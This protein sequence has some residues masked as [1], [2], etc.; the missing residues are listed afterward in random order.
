[1]TQAKTREQVV[2]AIYDA[3]L[4]PGSYDTFMDH[5]AETL[6]ESLDSLE[7]LKN[8][9]KDAGHLKDDPELEAHFERAFEILERFGRK[10]DATKPAEPITDNAVFAL[11]VNAQ[12]KIV[13]SSDKARKTLGPTPELPVLLK[14]L[15]S[16]SVTQLKNMLAG[17]GQRPANDAGVILTSDLD[18]GYLLARADVFDPA[19]DANGAT[20]TIEALEIPWSPEI[21]TTLAAS[22]GFSKAEM[23]VIREMTRGNVAKEIAENLNKSEHTVRNHIKS[24]LSKSGA[25]GQVD[26]MRLVSILSGSKTAKRPG[27]AASE[28]ANAPRERLITLSGGKTMQVVYFGR[29]GGFPV[30]FFHGMLDALAALRTNE[31][32]IH[33]SGLRF[34]APMRPGFGHSTASDTPAS[35]LPEFLRNVT[36]LLDSEG[37]QQTLVMGHMAGSV[38]AHALAKRLPSRVAAVFNISGGVP[39]TRL[40]QFSHMA[41]RQRTVAYT[42]R[43]AERLLPTILRAGISQIDNKQISDFMDALFQ[44]GTYDNKLIARLGVID[45][46]RQD[47]RLSV[48]QGHKGFQADSHYVVRD[49]SDQ[50]APASVPCVHYH[51][52]LDPVVSP[53]SVEAFAERFPNVDLTMYPDKGQLILYE[54]ARKI[55]D[56]LN[57]TI[58]GLAENP[59]FAAS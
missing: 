14:H 40:S 4:K 49:W 47:Y 12:S 26:L 29:E 51:G 27:D 18:T 36:E 9:E 53:Q 37:I 52:A 24:V 1:M 5:W 34:I 21:A 44:P 17:L 41:R 7:T 30:L 15:N 54:Q 59:V 57:D 58:D 45:T 43:F 2:A 46:M 28:P 13:A 20:L 55:F 16:Q 25:A 19:S 33:A 3:A 56:D 38:Y 48:L 10:S 6:A 11:R 42:A 32:Q 50:V 39:I 35:V 23:A 31:R 22:F 8:A